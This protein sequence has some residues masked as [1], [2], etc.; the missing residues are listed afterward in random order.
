MKTA[1]YTELRSNLAHILDSVSTDHEPMLITRGAG[2]PAVLLSLEDYNSF[3]ETMHLMGST[4]NAKRL[5]DAISSLRE[6]Q[7]LEKQLIED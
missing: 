7:G 4:A 5:N 1:T 6:G 3:M 2:S